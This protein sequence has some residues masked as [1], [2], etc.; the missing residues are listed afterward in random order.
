ML[1]VPVASDRVMLAA[2]DVVD[3]EVKLTVPVLWLTVRAE[4]IL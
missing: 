4:P 1:V 2:V 3:C